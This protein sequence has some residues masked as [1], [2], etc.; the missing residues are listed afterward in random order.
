VTTTGGGVT[1]GGG[2]TTTGGGVTG[3]GGGVTG[4][5]GGVTGVGAAV[6][7][8]G[9][10]VA[11]AAGGVTEDGELDEEEPAG[12]VDAPYPHPADVPRY[13]ARTSHRKCRGL[14]C[15]TSIM[16]FPILDQDGCVH[17]TPDRT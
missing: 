11:G 2:V 10:G 3:V 15:P 7:G 14:I 17:S 5:G 8:A 1:G 4:A 13:D 16:R 12:A 9:G 6:T